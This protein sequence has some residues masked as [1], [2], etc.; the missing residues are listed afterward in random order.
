MAI[1]QGLETQPAGQFV[2]PFGDLSGGPTA[3]IKREGEVLTHR[4]VGE[5]RAVLGDES[6]TA[7]AGGRVGDVLS[8]DPDDAGNHRAKTAD[9]FEQGGLP[10]AGPAHQRGVASPRDPTGKV[11][12]AEAADLK[13][14]VVEFDHLRGGG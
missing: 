7:R 3:E 1:E 9:G 13:G 12:Q 8:V 4:Q 2:H 14:E 11:V 6:Q 5:Q 10:G